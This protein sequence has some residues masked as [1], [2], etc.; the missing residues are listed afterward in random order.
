MGDFFGGLEA[1]RGVDGGAVARS[2]GLALH[3]AGV[4]P[5]FC[6]HVL[7]AGEEV[8]RGFRCALEWAPGDGTWRRAW[9]RECSRVERSGEDT[10]SGSA[11]VMRWYF[12]ELEIGPWRHVVSAL[13]TDTNGVMVHRQDYMGGQV[14]AAFPPSPGMSYVYQLRWELWANPAL[15]VEGGG[16]PRDETGRFTNASEELRRSQTAA[17]RGG[18]G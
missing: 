8:L 10:I 9:F 12:E 15:R 18:G 6:L 1:L 2:W 7:T 13:L 3:G 11:L 14:R 5:K 4:W 17:L 16:R